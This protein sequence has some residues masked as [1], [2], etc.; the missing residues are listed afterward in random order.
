[1]T[2]VG[3]RSTHVPRGAGETISFMGMDLVWK[4]T[5]EMSRGS[6]ISFLQVAPRDTGVPMHIH[7][8]EDEF[9]YCAAGTLRFQLG[10]EQFDV[11]LGDV[12]LMP[13]GKPHG[14]RITSDEPAEILFT[15]DL[16]PASDYE[17]MFNGLVGLAPTDFEQIQAVCAANDVEFLS[18]PA[19]P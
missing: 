7:H 9:I 12:V 19:M 18:P 2:M 3:G 15:L 5:S 8:N 16:S 11:G 10:D 13:K 17:A 6:L 14:F 4:V 1:M